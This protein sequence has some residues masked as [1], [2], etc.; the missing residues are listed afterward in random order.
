MASKPSRVPEL[1]AP[2]AIVRPAVTVASSTAPPVAV[3]AAV[4]APEANLSAWIEIVPVPVIDNPP[5]APIVTPLACVSTSRM[6][7]PL[8][9]SATAPLTVS[10][11]LSVSRKSPLDAL[12]PASVVIVF[13]SFSVTLLALPVSVPTLSVN[14]DPCVT[15]AVVSRSS[16]DASPPVRSVAA[17]TVIALPPTVPLI[18][19]SRSVFA[20]SVYAVGLN[21]SS[22]PVLATPS[23]I[24]RAEFGANSITPEAAVSAAVL[25][26][27][28]N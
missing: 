3:S 9:L 5:A 14:P 18:E 8:E 13:A 21:P 6:F 25:A 19:P 16:V 22:A 23:E 20:L 27:E 26:P 24:P 28:A 7:L 2:S 11:T 1:A 12:K 4:L 10:A 17:A 15:A